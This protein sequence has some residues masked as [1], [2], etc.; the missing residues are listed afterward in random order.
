MIEGQHSGRLWL[1]EDYLHVYVR[2]VFRLGMA[3]ALL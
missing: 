2:P 1:M 3:T